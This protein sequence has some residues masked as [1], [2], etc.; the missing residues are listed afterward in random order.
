[1]AQQLKKQVEMQKCKS[2]ETYY[3]RYLLNQG[4]C[5]QCQNKPSIPEKDLDNQ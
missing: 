4:L 1:M 3:A 2:C 5:S